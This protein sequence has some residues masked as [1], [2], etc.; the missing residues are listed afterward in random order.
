MAVNYWNK[1]G[2]A[3][4]RVMSN[5]STLDNQ[6]GALGLTLADNEVSAHSKY[7][8]YF[9]FEK[10]HLAIKCDILDKIWSQSDGYDEAGPSWFLKGNLEQEWMAEDVWAEF[11]AMLQAGRE[12]TQNQ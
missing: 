5:Q 9:P 1:I 6:A 8:Q 2:H 12:R 10:R 3:A 7:V 11:L 4:M